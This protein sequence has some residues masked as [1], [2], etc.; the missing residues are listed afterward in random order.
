MAMGMVA[1]GAS[2]T[3][4]ILIRKCKFIGPL[5]FIVPQLIN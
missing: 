5:S 4:A 3:K 1:S 2:L